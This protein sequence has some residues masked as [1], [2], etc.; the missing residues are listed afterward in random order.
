MRHP[1]ACGGKGKPAPFGRKRIV[2]NTHGML[3]ALYDWKAVAAQEKPQWSEGP[4]Y[5]L[6][7]RIRGEEENHV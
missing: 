6:K 4:Q 3:P 1:T 7:Q 2:N 5:V